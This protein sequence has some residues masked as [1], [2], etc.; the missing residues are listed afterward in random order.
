MSLRVRDLHPFLDEDGAIFTRTRLQNAATADKAKF[1]VL[2]SGDHR[3]TELLMEHAHGHILHG[4]VNDTLCE[5]REHYWVVRAR[6]CV[7]R[8]IRRCKLCLRFKLKTPMAPLP[9]DPVMK[10]E[11]FKVSGV[12]F[13]GP[14]FAKS[15][16]QCV[17]AYITVFTCFMTRS[18][19]QEL[20][21]DMSTNSFLMAFRSFVP[22]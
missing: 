22:R 16:H 15:G 14:M 12:G 20:V 21:W 10:A 6:Q 11:P 1:P 3:F 18:I 8:V 19:H 2:L 4:G 5:L 7:K 13:A 17:K 9:A